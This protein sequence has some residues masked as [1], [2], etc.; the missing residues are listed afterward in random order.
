MNLNRMLERCEKHQWSANDLDFSAPPRP[1]RPEAERAVVQYFTDMAGIEMLAARMFEVQQRNTDDPVLRAIFESFV[2]DERRHSVVA[3]RLADH[4][5]V[6]RY[7]RYRRSPGLVDFAEAF[8]E[9]AQYLA[10]EIANTYITVG[11]LMLDVALLRSLD[12]YVDDPTCHNAMRLI[13][14]DESRHIAID[15]HMIEHYA[16][17]AAE[18]DARERRK[19][20]LVKAKGF[21]ALVGALRTARPFAKRVFFDTMQVV[22]PEGRR[23]AE[24]FKR[25][26]L[27]GRRPNVASRP[28]SRFTNALQDLGNDPKLGPLFMPIAERVLGVDR[29]FLR[30]LYDEEEVSWAVNASMDELARDALAAKTLH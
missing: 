18:T 20:L 23:M 12:D 7:E 17:H 3:Q 1:M 21:V 14:R 25:A 10:P 27:I 22:D 8:E 6:H 11:E 26:Q 24:A 29:Q 19:P 30:V 28:F 13:N 16:T 5:D 2:A 4:Y 9:L 15:F